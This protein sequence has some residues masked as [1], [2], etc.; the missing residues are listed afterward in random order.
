MTIR[1]YPLPNH[2]QN[3]TYT[4]NTQKLLSMEHDLHRRT[5]T[6]EN[7]V[8]MDHYYSAVMLTGMHYA[9]VSFGADYGVIVPASQAHMIAQSIA[10]GIPDKDSTRNGYRPFNKAECTVR[11]LSHHEHR[12]NWLANY[13]NT[14]AQKIGEMITFNPAELSSDE[15][16]ADYASPD[17]GN[18]HLEPTSFDKDLASKSD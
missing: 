16:P 9:L 11:V 14:S 17:M 18:E 1:Q 5:L 3:R 4:M 2:L 6:T 7:L 10:G 13:F 15:C 8:R 12:M